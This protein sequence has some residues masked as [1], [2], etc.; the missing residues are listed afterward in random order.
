MVNTEPTVRMTDTYT[1]PDFVRVQTW[2]DA[3][4]DGCLLATIEHFSYR[5]AGDDERSGWHCLTVADAEAMSREDA[6]FIARSYAQQNGIPV[7]YNADG[8]E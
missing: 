5:P 2:A 6:L 8:D 4:R 7:V 1:E 3:A